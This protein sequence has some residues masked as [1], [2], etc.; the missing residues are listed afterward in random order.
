MNYTKDEIFQRI[1]I[2]LE[3]QF[4]VDREAVTLDARLRDDLDI[5]SID[6]VNLVIEL[7]SVTGR[8]LSIE[9]FHKVQTIGDV[10]NAV[11]TFLEQDSNA[12]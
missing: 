3:E 8:K 1:A 6:A 10:V 9:N 2:I 11:H 7:K 5:D 4:E 12:P